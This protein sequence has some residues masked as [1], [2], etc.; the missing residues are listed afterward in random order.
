MRFFYRNPDREKIMISGY[1][2]SHRIWLY[3]I[4][5]FLFLSIMLSG[6][7]KII[8]GDEILSLS[9]QIESHHI[10]H[11]EVCIPVKA[12]EPFRILWGKDES[13]GSIQGIM[14]PSQKDGYS[15]SLSISEG[16]GQCQEKT[17]IEL[18]EG[19][20]N[21]WAL[22]ASSAF[23]HIDNRRFFLIKGECK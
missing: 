6:Q 9:I 2:V 18:K 13:R 5:L 22:V 14:K 19:K 10:S 1:H 4:S 8:A 17:V 12:N 16:A 3:K 23:S 11:F 15:L 20:A 7:S 21:E